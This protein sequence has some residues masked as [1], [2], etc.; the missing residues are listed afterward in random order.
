MADILPTYLEDRRSYRRLYD[1]SET[2]TVFSL[3]CTFHWALNA[4]YL[5]SVSV[6]IWINWNDRVKNETAVLGVK[7]GRN[8]LQTT[9]RRKAS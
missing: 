3:I 5:F 8:V 2:L 1:Q 4:A 6:N 9:K 7:K